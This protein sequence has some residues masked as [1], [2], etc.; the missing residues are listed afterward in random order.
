MKPHKKTQVG[1]PKTWEEMIGIFDIEKWLPAINILDNPEIVEDLCDA[2]HLSIVVMRSELTN[3][4]KTKELTRLCQYYY[5]GLKRIYMIN[6]IVHG[7]A[8]PKYLSQQ[9]K[10]KMIITNRGNEALK[11]CSSKTKVEGINEETV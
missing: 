6:L 1:L 2:I 4:I 9:K 11:K 10:P 8:V 3:G 7:F 5:E